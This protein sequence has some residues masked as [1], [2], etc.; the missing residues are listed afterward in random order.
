MAS[1]TKSNPFTQ[2][3]TEFREKVT[4]L[5]GDVEELSKITKELASDTVSLLRENTSG[6]YENGKKKAMQLEKNFETMIRENPVRSLMFA[7]GVGLF[8]GIL[9]HRR[10]KS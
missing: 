7:T 5:G 6:Y 10:K 9:W 2:H 8:V 4:A 3:A 1:S